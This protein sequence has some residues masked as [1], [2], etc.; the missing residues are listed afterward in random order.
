ML[1]VSRRYG[2]V[3]QVAL[4]RHAMYRHVNID[5]IGNVM[6]ILQYTTDIHAYHVCIYIRVYTHIDT[7]IFAAIDQGLGKQPQNRVYNTAT[8]SSSAS[9]DLL[10]RV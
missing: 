3:P 6:P 8:N 4:L 7:M 9:E 5:A 1:P 2:A 10:F